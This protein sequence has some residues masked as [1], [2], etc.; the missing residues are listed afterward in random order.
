[1]SFG[2]HIAV[3][4]WQRFCA[5]SK[6]SLATHLHGTSVQPISL[7]HHESLYSLVP[8]AMYILQLLLPIFCHLYSVTLLVMD[9]HPPSHGWAS[10]ADWRRFRSIITELYEHNPLK[11]V[12]EIMEAQHGFQ[13]T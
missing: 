7:L 8:N 12:K 1:M 13:A 2:N 5:S 6:C 4:H 10:Q 3:H 11:K 9:A